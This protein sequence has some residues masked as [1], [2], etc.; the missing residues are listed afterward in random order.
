MKVLHLS[1]SLTKPQRLQLTTVPGRAGPGAPP[2]LVGVG[3]EE[4]ETRLLEVGA[5]SGSLEALTQYDFLV[6]RFLHLA[7]M[8]VFTA[9]VNDTSWVL[10]GFRN[11]KRGRD[12]P[13]L[14]FS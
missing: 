9:K 3:V 7:V 2:G 4:L 10:R 6:L 5:G 13:S 8:G 11:T 1:S 12:Y 14:E